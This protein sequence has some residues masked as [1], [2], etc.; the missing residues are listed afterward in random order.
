MT[1]IRY[2]IFAV[3]AVVVMTGCFSGAA[4]APA[5]RHYTLEYTL[6]AMEQK[7]V[8]DGT[9]RVERFAADHDYQGRDM[10]YRPGP[11]VRQAYRT[12]RWNG[13]PADMVQDKL[14]KDL[15]QAGFFKVILSPDDMGSARY[16][17]NG[18]ITEFL[19]IDE[20]DRSL[21]AFSVNVTVEDLMSQEEGRVVL[22]KTYRIVE[23]FAFGEPDKLAPAMSTAMMRFSLALFSDLRRVLA[24]V[25]P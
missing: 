21:A 23:P 25:K 9:I 14:L 1:P 18:R 4:S 2:K 19:E 5:I 17:I 20:K 10:I 6:P 11:Y 3:L 22:Q 13:A 12:H 7:P 8:V 16:A 15:H 24:V